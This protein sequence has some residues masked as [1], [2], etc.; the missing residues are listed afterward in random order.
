VLLEALNGKSANLVSIGV[1]YPSKLSEDLV[2]NEV[3]K[4]LPRSA[5]FHNY[6]INNIEDLDADTKLMTIHAKIS[7]INKVSC[8]ENDEIAL[9]IELL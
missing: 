9:S 4:L 6:N 3:K 5:K 2:I 8:L 7:D 1:S